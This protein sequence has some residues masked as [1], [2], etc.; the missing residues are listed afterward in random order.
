MKLECFTKLNTFMWLTNCT[1][2]IPKSDIELTETCAPLHRQLKAF[3]SKHC[4]IKYFSIINQRQNGII[5][6]L[7]VIQNAS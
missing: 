1:Q 2:N 5:S 4:C 6:F 3:E 7:T